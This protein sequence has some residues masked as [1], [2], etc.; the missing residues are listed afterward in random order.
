M[1]IQKNGEWLYLGSPINRPRLVQLF[2]SVLR[3]DPDGSTWLVTPGEK[4]RID[5]EDAHFQ[6]VLLDVEERKGESAFVFTTN[7]GER[8]VADA[9]HLID[10]QY[11]DKNGEPQPYLHVRDGLTARITRAVFISLGERAVV[12]GAVAGVSS[13]GHFMPLGPAE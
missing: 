5:V 2:A 9:E 13:C 7:I 11:P 1:R 8:V 10:V 3:V 6:A 12:K 4:L